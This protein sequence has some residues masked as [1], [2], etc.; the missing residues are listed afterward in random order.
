MLKRACLVFLIILVCNFLRFAQAAVNIQNFNHSNSFGFES[1]NSL[2]VD[3]SEIPVVKNYSLNLAYSYN[4][5]PLVMKNLENNVIVGPMARDLRVL[6]LGG[7][8]RL[9]PNL[10]F[11]L[12]SNL[13]GVQLLNQDRSWKPQDTQLELNYTFLRR[14]KFALGM[15]PFLTLPNGD[16]ASYLSDS[17]TGVGLLVMSQFELASFNFVTG[18][19]YRRADRAVDAWDPNLSWQQ[20]MILELGLL[21]R[22][23]AKWNLLVEF[24]REYRLPLSSDLN[25]NIFLLAGRYAMNASTGLFI[26]VGSSDL[27]SSATN[28]LR[29][30]VGIKYSPHTRAPL[31]RPHD[32]TP[33][34]ERFLLNYEHNKDQSY[35]ADAIRRIH[36]FTQVNRE[37]I[38]AVRVVGHTSSLGTDDYNA[39]L[40]QKR[41]ESVK[42]LLL[43][44]GISN[45]MLV[46]EG[47]GERELIDQG[48]DERAHER[49]R[50]VEIL[51]EFVPKFSEVC[52]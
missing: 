6:H 13:V 3:E 16:A 12:M 10:S 49:N 42:E 8:Y 4:S 26:G 9:N 21:K 44:A 48:Q 30:S 7:Q 41:A 5:R 28:D 14:E 25:P 11:G 31:C 23:S 50:R 36:G 33:P 51:V 2:L 35:M 27:T 22:V 17:S 37:K 38:T 29:A 46:A 34:P 19:G 1:I 47:R 32:D 52:E 20:R 24:K 43:Q 15:V 40:S 39:E 45:E 18:V